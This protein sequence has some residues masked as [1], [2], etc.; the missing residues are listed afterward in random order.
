[1]ITAIVATKS[2]KNQIV[3]TRIRELNE[4]AYLVI[5]KIENKIKDIYLYGDVVYAF[6]KEIN[7]EMGYFFIS[8]TDEIVKLEQNLRR[9]GQNIE[10]I[11]YFKNTVFFYSE[12]RE[13]DENIEV[14]TIDNDDSDFLTGFWSEYDCSTRNQPISDLRKEFD[15][16]IEDAKDYYDKEIIKFYKK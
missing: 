7:N 10:F 16:T 14:D 13:K 6:E 8:I 4:K 9:A 15:K 3:E 2:W 1:M 11:E 12:K 5:D